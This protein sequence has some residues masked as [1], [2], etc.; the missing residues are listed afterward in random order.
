MAL[1]GNLHEVDVPGLVE[2]ARH[3]ALHA[4]V[5]VQ[6]GGQTF[7]LYISDGE[8]VHASGAGL[9]G[10][11]ALYAAL[12]CETGTFE[13]EK[14]APPPPTTTLDLP[15]NTLLLQALQHLDETRA[16]LDALSPPQETHMAGKEKPEE[17]I[18]EMA[19]DL[20]PGLHGIGVIGTDGLGIAFHKVGGDTAEMLGSQMALIMQLSRR[21]TE[22]VEKSA[23]ED[24]LVT[25]DK[26]YLL[27]RVLGDGSYFLVVSVSRDSVLGN[28]RLA[29]RTYTD[30]I[31]KS[32]PGA[33]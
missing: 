6:S 9:S 18:K 33:R 4:Q 19:T 3:S 26:S 22:R 21:S 31:L 25:T 10:E 23:V 15:W 12:G 16:T 30:R 32:I 5:T 29:M 2:L 11:R 1:V 27:G 8:V 14:N 20:E 17:V 13:L 28:V 24:V 7:R